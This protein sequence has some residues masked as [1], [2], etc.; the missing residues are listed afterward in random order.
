MGGSAF[1]SGEHALNT[2]RMPP[3]IYHHVKAKCL[4]ALRELYICVASPIE[5]P[6]KEDFGDID[7]VVTW[8][9]AAFQGRCCAIATPTAAAENTHIDSAKRDFDDW[10]DEGIDDEEGQECSP[11]HSLM[12]RP[13]AREAIRAALGAEYFIFNK[14]GDHYAIPWPSCDADDTIDEGLKRYIQ[15]DITICDSLQQ[16]QWLLFKHA[17][18]DLWSILGTIIKPYTLTADGHALFL[19]NPDIEKFDK[20]KSRARIRL[21]RDPAEILLFLGMDVARYSE[22][23]ASRQEM[24]EYAASCR[25]FRIWPDEGDG[26]SGQVESASSPL[27]MEPAT[28][29]TIPDYAWSPTSIEPATPATT[30]EPDTPAVSELKPGDGRGEPAKK[31]LKAKDKRRLKTRPAFRQW[32]EEFVPLCRAEGRCFG[33]KT[34][35]LKV[36]EE[37]FERFGVISWYK[38]VHLDVVRC[39]SEDRVMVDVLK[40]IDD[41]VPA[42]P[43]NPKR[44][45]FRG[46]LKKALKKIIFEGDESFGVVPKNDLRDGLGLMIKDEVDKFVSKSWEEV[47]RAAMA[48]H[49]QRYEEHCRDTGKGKRE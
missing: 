25:L 11:S 44:C 1:A 30:M 19:R 13:D 12:S 38:R 6:E 18:G 37:A 8:E 16:M 43:T 3:K 45:Q 22:P 21:T 39:R 28:P 4:S 47:G 9:K 23:F 49:Q 33:E 46:G 2:P 42:D 35:W 26:E 36:T 41:V 27:S 31:K 29:S 5:G 32:Y 17:H 40:T 15:V 20:Y 24:F 7:I 10:G 48:K 34:T 14:V